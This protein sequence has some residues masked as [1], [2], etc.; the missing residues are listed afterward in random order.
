MMSQQESRFHFH[1]YN[2]NQTR[3]LSML[4]AIFWC[5][6]VACFSTHFSNLKRLKRDL[7][8]FFSNCI[9]LTTCLCLHEAACFMTFK[10]WLKKNQHD[11][12][13]QRVWGVITWKLLFSGGDKNLRG[14][15]LGG[16]F[17]RWGEGMNRF[18]VSG[19]TPIPP[20]VEVLVLMQH[21][22]TY[23]YL[24]SLDISNWHV[25]KITSLS[26]TIEIFLKQNLSQT[27]LQTFK[28]CQI[29]P[30]Y[31]QKLP[32][33]K[34]LAIKKSYRKHFSFIKVF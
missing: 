31:T 28:T 34:N 16:N 18:L 30:K 29:L 24:F 15:L 9:V 2:N 8:N 1:F 19:G 25:T 20:A 14:T 33:W 7:N 11:L 5:V 32:L 6:A 23:T 10:C 4:A 13:V 26:T 21:L 17:S 3:K 12:C 27:Y 22:F